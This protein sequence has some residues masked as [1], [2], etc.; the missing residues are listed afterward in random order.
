MTDTA[1]GR[2]MG[3]VS[4]E[5]C[6]VCD[7]IPRV[8]VAV[9]HSVMRRYAAELLSRECGCWAS[10]DVA[11]NEMLPGAIERFQPDLLVVDVGDFPAC[12]QAAIDSFPRDRVVVIGPE[13]DPSYGAVALAKGAAACVT[14]DNVG[15][16]LVPAM[17][18]VLGC[19]HD[20]CPP[21][22]EAPHARLVAT[23]GEQS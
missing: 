10:S 15:E 18:S 7:A 20:H 5:P 16:E 4:S 14:R 11:A 3:R 1:E 6:P 17:R 19:R 8:L 9:R 22:S 23:A 12:C 13:P 21:S 2:T